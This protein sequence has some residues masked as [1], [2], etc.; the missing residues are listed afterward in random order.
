M[1]EIKVGDKVKVHPE[2]IVF[3]VRDIVGKMAVIETKFGEKYPPTPLSMLDKV[4]DEQ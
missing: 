2:G 3:I 1:S 4:E